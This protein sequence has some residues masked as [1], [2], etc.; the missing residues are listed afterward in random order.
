MGMLSLI[1]VTKKTLDSRVTDF[2]LHLQ[3]LPFI[4][5]CVL[6]DSSAFCMLFFRGEAFGAAV[7]AQ[8][9]RF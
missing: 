5:L 3:G 6:Q 1:T 2:S 9:K 8:G 4:V 7:T